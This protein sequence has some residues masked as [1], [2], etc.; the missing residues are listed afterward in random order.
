MKKKK[1]FTRLNKSAINIAFIPNDLLHL[2][3]VFFCGF[4]KKKKLY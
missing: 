2:V 3:A 1:L 4:Q